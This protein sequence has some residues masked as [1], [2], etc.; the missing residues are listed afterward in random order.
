MKHIP[1]ITYTY[2][3]ICPITSL[4]YEV[5]LKMSPT[6]SPFIAQNK[7]NSE[8]GIESKYPRIGQKKHVPARV[9]PINTGIVPNITFSTNGIARENVLEMTV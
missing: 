3:Y 2:V 5:P 7:V 9:N 4:D 1:N 8:L 6:E